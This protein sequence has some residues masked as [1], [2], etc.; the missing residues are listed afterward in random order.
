MVSSRIRVSSTKW[1][2]RK[3]YYHRLVHY[4]NDKVFIWFW[5][6]AF[7]RVIWEFPKNFIISSQRYRNRQ[8]RVNLMQVVWYYTYFMLLGQWFNFPEFHHHVSKAWH[9]FIFWNYWF[10]ID[11]LGSLLRYKL[12]WYW[13]WE[14]C[15]HSMDCSSKQ[16]F[17]LAP[18]QQRIGLSWCAGKQL[19]T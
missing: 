7:V 5:W 3:Q 11:E 6:K 10:I 13:C 16:V 4:W 9:V 14:A 2:L 15:C 19:W 12:W 18:S 8:C 1:V 17:G